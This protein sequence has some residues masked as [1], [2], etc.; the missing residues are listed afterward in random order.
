MSVSARL[1]QLTIRGDKAP[2]IEVSLYKLFPVHLFMRFAYI[3]N[4]RLIE[5][6]RK[7]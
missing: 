4:K 1:V 2:R 3:E 5:G 6:R 7:E